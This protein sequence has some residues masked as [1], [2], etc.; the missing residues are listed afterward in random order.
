MASTNPVFR[1]DGS[2]KKPQLFCGKYFDF[3]EICI[4]ARLEA[5]GKEI[6]NVIEN[7]PFIPTSVINGVGTPKIKS[8]W[9][10]MIRKRASIT[11]KK[12]TYFKVH[13]A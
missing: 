1:D 13:L 12:S 9:M 4:K 5:Q 7:G 8:S 11:T 3:W 6:W 10:K 2:N